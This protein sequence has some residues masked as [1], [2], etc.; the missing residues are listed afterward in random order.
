MSVTARRRLLLPLPFP[1]ANIHASFMQFLPGKLLTPDQVTFLKTDNVVAPDALTLRD[2]GI[3]PD[4]LEA[5]LP[6]YLWRFRKKGQFEN[7][8]SERVS[9]TP[10]VR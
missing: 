5:V 1:L 2:L 6:S 8:A 7:S 10:A 9:G 3:E 4:L